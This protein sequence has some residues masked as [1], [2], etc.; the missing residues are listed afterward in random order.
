M[1]AASASSARRGPSNLPC[2]AL[3]AGALLWQAVSGVAAAGEHHRHHDAA[4]ERC[5]A[6]PQRSQELEA[7]ARVQGERARQARSAEVPPQFHAALQR[8]RKVARLPKGVQLELVGID[9]G[10]SASVLAS[11]TIIVSNRLWRGE[12]ALDAD[13]MAA[14]VAHELAH[15]EL[16]HVKERLCA[17]VAVAGDDG[18]PL[19]AATGAARR[20]IHAGD[21]RL[22]VRMIQGN[23]QR[24]LDADR[25]A[26]DLLRL[27]GIAPDAVGRMLLKLARR[28]GGEP[29]G[30]HPALE[31]R[32]ENLGLAIAH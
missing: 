19:A 10:H 7:G 23:H 3:L 32:L 31:T 25:R 16:S 30:T 22:A 9:A 5:I 17:A 21:D 8:V 26:A 28:D 24:E 11:G 6:S 13:E 18:I 29:S 4:Q 15:L 1:T 20:V 27:A 2:A 12:L 14:V